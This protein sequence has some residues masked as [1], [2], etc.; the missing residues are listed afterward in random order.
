MATITKRK[1]KKSNSYLLRC[2]CGYDITGQQIEHTAT[3]RPPADM[4]ERQADKEA[5]RQAFLFEERCRTGQ[6]L[7]GS[8]RFADYAEKWF[9]ERGELTLR[10]RTIASYRSYITRINNT[11][12]RR[13]RAYPAR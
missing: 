2:Y 3:W 12:Q 5:L 9:K 10:P 7:D 1:G 11:H 4:T 13:Y 6:V 8:I